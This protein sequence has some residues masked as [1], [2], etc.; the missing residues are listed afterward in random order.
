MKKDVL[1]ERIEELVRPIVSELSCELYY[2]EY[3]KENGEFY[4]RIYIDKEGRVSLNDCEAVSRRVS[5]VLDSEDPIK[6]SYYLEVSSPGLNRGLYKEEHFN[7]YIG[8]EVLIRLTSSLNGVKSVKGV[9][10]DVSEDSILVEGETEVKIPR[11]KIKAA[12]LEGE[13]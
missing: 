4:L 10:R 7:K 9:L 6:E 11:D 3:V 13:I 8:R 2:V 12:N 5:D 1:I